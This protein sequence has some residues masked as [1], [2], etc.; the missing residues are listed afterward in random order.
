MVSPG[1]SFQ[2]LSSEGD[3]RLTIL[4]LELLEVLDEHPEPRVQTRVLVLEATDLARG[5]R[6]QAGETTT[7]MFDS[8]D[9][10]WQQLRRLR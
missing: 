6:A 9:P 5:F 8:R 4:V 2:F 10:E 1:D 3:L 7:W